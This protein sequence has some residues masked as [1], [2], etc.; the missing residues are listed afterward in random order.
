MRRRDFLTAGSGAIL[1]AALTSAPSWAAGYRVGVG[2]SEDPYAATQRAIEGSGEWPRAAVAGRTVVIKPNL[3]APAAPETGM[4]TDPRVVQAVVD[5]AL[6]DGARAVTIVETSRHGAFF[7]QTGYRLFDDYDER[8]TLLDLRDVSPV[9]APVAGGGLAYG[10]VWVPSAVLGDDVV[11]VSA[12]K[13]KTHL[14]AMATLATKNLFGL[15]V[16]ERYMPNEGKS[17]RFTMHERGLHLTISDL[18]RIRPV[19][20]CVVDGGVVAMEGRGPLAGEP[21]AMG[22]V[23]AGANPIAVDCV[24]LHAMNIAPQFV[25]HLTYCARMGLGPS[26]LS[27]VTVHGDALVPRA[28]ALPSPPPLLGYPRIHPVVFAPRRGQSTTLQFAYGEPTFRMLRI[29]RYDDEEP[30]TAVVRTLLPDSYYDT[31]TEVVTWDGRDEEGQYAP[32]GVYAVQVTAWSLRAVVRPAAV[33]A[34]L[35]VV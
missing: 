11:F 15:P 27:G 12:A 18:L 7:E 22:T 5:R 9:L 21:V 30:A 31:G 1:G 24:A 6:A 33:T 16:L 20:F 32:A 4:V 2:R 26:D 13:M 29:V 23:L 8:V 34:W 3:V 10:A 17:G 19:H 25:P 28:F 35:R 14:E